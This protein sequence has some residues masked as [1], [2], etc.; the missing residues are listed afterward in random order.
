METARITDLEVPGPAEGRIAG[1]PNRLGSVRVPVRL[2]E[3][4]GEPWG[5]LVWAHGG[6]FIHGDLDWPEAD[7]VAA[8]FAEAGLRVYSVDYALAAETVKAPAPANDVAAVLRWAA[9]GHDG[10]LIIG[11]ASAGGNL[12]VQAALRQAA[13]VGAAD[14]RAADALILVYPTLHRWQREA[15]EIEVLVAELGARWRFGPERVAKMYDFYLGS[16]LTAV[17]G[18]AAVRD[19]SELGG[20]STAPIVV[21]ELPAERLAELPATLLVN[22]ELDDL[23]GSGEQFAEQLITAGVRVSCSTQPRALHGYL[24]R[25]HESPIELAHGRETIAVLVAGLRAALVR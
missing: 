7:W 3:P 16:E 17:A 14:A 2:Y 11:G 25:V 6:S 13:L 21:G 1:M 5:T 4:A 22:A 19:V 23:R 20:I 15:P 9:T 24:N 10:P 18:P 8:S 12:A